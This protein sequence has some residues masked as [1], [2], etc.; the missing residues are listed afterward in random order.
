MPLRRLGTSRARPRSSKSCGSASR[1]A[2]ASTDAT[3]VLL[4][5][6]PLLGLFQQRAC[7]LV[8]G[9]KIDVQ[10]LQ[11]VVDDPRDLPACVM[12][13]VR[14]YGI[15]RRPGPRRRAQARV[16]GIEILVP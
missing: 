3:S 15:P 6:Q 7:F 14:G 10:L 11:R 2:A 8:H 9:P 4:G 13:V 5:Q 1:G 16:V 12:L